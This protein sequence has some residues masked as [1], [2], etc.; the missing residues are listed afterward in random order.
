MAK[1]PNSIEILRKISTACKVAR[2]L[3]TTDR[4]ATA[5]SDENTEKINANCAAAVVRNSKLLVF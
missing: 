4:Q 1:V 3:Q 5:K 2:A